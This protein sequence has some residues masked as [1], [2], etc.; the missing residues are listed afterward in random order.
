[1]TEAPKTYR[2]AQK[3]GLTNNNIYD[4]LF[5]FRNKRVESYEI[6]MKRLKNK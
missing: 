2:A 3:R 1:M 4:K 6:V 5:F